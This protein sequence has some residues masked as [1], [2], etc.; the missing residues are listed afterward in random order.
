MDTELSQN[1]SC[2]IRKLVSS[3]KYIELCSQAWMLDAT[4]SERGSVYGLP[5][6]S[7]YITFNKFSVL[8]FLTFMFQKG[9]K[10]FN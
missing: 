9:E 8:Y 3:S 7:L 6:E 4:G 2:K 10:I 1:I 5:E